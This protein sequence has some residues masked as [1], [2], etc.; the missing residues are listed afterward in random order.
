MIRIGPMQARPVD[1]RRQRERSGR[2]AELTAAVVLCLKG[3]RILARRY[4]SKA[5]EID[6]IAVRGRRLAFVEVKRR[7]TMEAAEAAK[8]FRQ[9]Q[10]MARAA[11]QWVWRHPAYRNHEIG[12]DALL[13]VPGRLP[14]H[15]PNALQRA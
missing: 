10:R 4:R 9:A 15:Q 6:L 3:Y 2:L 13:L 5:G 7:R 1:I 8:T 12:L 11:E 14:C